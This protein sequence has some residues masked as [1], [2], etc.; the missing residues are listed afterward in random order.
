MT[1]DVNFQH[2]YPSRYYKIFTKQRSA[3]S[4]RIATDC[5]LVPSPL[6]ASNVPAVARSA[7]D[8]VAQQERDAADGAG[9][10]PPRRRVRGEPRRAVAATLHARQDQREAASPARHLP[11]PLSAS[12]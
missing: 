7:A 8:G 3:A 6:A 5:F 12:R 9:V 11:A 2:T 10:L 1:T 4:T